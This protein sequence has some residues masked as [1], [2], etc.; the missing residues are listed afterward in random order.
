[1]ILPAKRE[2]LEGKTVKE[3]KQMA[4]DRDLSGYSNLKKGGL[5]DMIRANYSRAEIQAWAEGPEP[6]EGAESMEL[7]GSEPKEE[8]EE[9][10]KGGIKEKAETV[11]KATA[12][13][14]IGGSAVIIVAFLILWAAGII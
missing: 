3:L 6:S 1:M 7:E 2:L 12:A 10:G 4:R 11:M 13:I 5:I 14:L 9:P 8:P